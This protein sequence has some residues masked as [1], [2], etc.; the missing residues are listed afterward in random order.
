MVDEHFGINVV[1]LMAAGLIPLTHASGGPL[2]DIV[3]P[4]QGEPTGPSMMAQA[5]LTPAGFHARDAQDFAAKLEAILELSEATQLAFRWR[6]RSSVVERFSSERF[7]AGW[8]EAWRA[9]RELE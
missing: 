1:E 7:E 3:V 4:Y 5:A 6:A 2:V 8:L 9:L